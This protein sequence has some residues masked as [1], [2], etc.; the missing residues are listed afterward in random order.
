[1]YTGT[2]KRAQAQRQYVCVLGGVSFFFGFQL[3][4]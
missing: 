4:L 3:P 2:G 1:M